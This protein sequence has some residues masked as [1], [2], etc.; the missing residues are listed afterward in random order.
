MR[1]VSKGED[2]CILLGEVFLLLYVQAYYAKDYNKTQV[3]DVGDAESKAEND[4]EDA[5]PS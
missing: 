2:G 4:A 1:S 3:E 5:E